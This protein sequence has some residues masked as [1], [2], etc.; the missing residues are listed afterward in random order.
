MLIHP[1]ITHELLSEREREAREAADKA[2]LVE[3]ATDNKTPDPIP[4]REPLRPLPKP[5]AAMR[6][7]A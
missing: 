1:F 7:C 5:Q 3:Q 4:T 2:L 6:G